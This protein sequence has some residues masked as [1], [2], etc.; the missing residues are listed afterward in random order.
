MDKK[1]SKRKRKAKSN[2]PTIVKIGDL[3]L[4]SIFELSRIFGVTAQTLRAHIKSGRIHG[5]KIG[6]TWF[7]STTALKNLFDKESVE[8]KGKSKDKE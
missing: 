3:E 4:Y 6:G 8:N 7:V 5:E 2:K 1:K